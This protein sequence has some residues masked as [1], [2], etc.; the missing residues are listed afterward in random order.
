MIYMDD[1]M[2]RDWN[3]EFSRICGV[4]SSLTSA[5]FGHDNADNG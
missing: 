4:A 2:T 5:G 1:D 3:L